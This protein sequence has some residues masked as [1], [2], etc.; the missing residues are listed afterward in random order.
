MEKV[1]L[2][3]SRYPKLV[4]DLATQNHYLKILSYS[5]IGVTTLMIVILAFAMKQ[6][7][8][9]IA[10]DPTGTVAS[11]GQELHVQHVQAA[12]K[13]YLSHRYNWNADTVTPELKKSEA[14]IFPSLLVSFQKGML[15]VQKY[16][17]ERKVS[18]R[19][20]PQSITVSLKDKIVTVVA[21]RITEFD[22]LKAAT[23][24]KSKLTF[25]L[26]SPTPSNPWGIFFVKEVEGGDTP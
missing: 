23:I 15:E 14:F 5:L 1:K 2:E 4:M 22:A 9:V 19:V 18:Q 17:K 10:L 3:N 8:A 25:E 6:G 26:D 13:E 16:V 7:P 21:D 11:V 12:V 24:L 20:Y